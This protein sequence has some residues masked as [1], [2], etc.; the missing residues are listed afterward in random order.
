MPVRIRKYAANQAEA[1]L[2]QPGLGRGHIFLRHGKRTVEPGN[3]CRR[4]KAVRRGGMAFIRNPR[5][6]CAMNGLRNGNTERLA[7][8]PCF[9]PRRQRRTGRLVEPHLLGIE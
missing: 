4:D 1:C 7:L 5:Q 2:C 9:L 8:K 3:V 6:V